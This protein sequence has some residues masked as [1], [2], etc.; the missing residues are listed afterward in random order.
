[1]DCI[2]GNAASVLAFPATKTG[3]RLSSYS[4]T[5]AAKM[6]SLKGKWMSWKSLGAGRGVQSVNKT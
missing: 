1:M 3:F 4:P 6:I 2:Q 5:G